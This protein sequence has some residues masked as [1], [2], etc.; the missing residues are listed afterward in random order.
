MKKI[1]VKI[2]DIDRKIIEN[3][4]IDEMTTYSTLVEEMAEYHRSLIWKRIVM[5]KRAGIIEVVDGMYKIADGIDVSKIYETSTI[6]IKPEMLNLSD[7]H[8]QI[9]KLLND[10]NKKTKFAFIKHKLNY[11]QWKLLTALEE[12]CFLGFVEKVRK[13][14]YQITDIGKKFVKQ[15]AV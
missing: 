10:T 1:V 14:I 13:G 3:I 15:Y 9:L 11:T 8:I 7:E 2:G 6:E 4:H 5:L 12:L